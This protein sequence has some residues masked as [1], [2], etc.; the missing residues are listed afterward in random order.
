MSDRV[1]LAD[2]DFEPTDEQL[3]ELSARA[4]AG[5]PSANRAALERI[6]AQIAHE[7]QIVL[8]ALEKA[9]A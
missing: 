6:R 1:N 3:Q 5:V 9:G 2:P 7:R 4:F 8:R